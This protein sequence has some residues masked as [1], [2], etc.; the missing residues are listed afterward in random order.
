MSFMRS[1]WERAIKPSLKM[2]YNGA[3]FVVQRPK[4][5][6][7]AALAVYAG[8]QFMDARKYT[9]KSPTQIASYMFH[10]TLSDAT[11]G[12]NML[13]KVYARI[14]GGET[15]PGDVITKPQYI[16]V[17]HPKTTDIVNGTEITHSPDLAAQ[18]DKME[19]DLRNDIQDSAKNIELRVS[20]RHNRHP[21]VTFD[22]SNVL[23]PVSIYHAGR[24]IDQKCDEP[25]GKAE[26]VR[27]P[28]FLI[29]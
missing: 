11:D 17:C 21:V 22:P 23:L 20:L 29:K 13:D 9:D 16:L 15:P 1:A 28:L 26:R 6:A 7:T 10:D 4:T 12:M 19:H 8:V 14:S 27:I 3:A 25:G 18:L 5:V 2:A 24:A